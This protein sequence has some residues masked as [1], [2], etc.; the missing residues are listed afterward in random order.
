MEFAV[1][2]LV[3][4]TRKDCGGRRA[5]RE[6]QIW[7]N[8]DT[9]QFRAQIVALCPDKRDFRVLPFYPD[10]RVSTRKRRAAKSKTVRI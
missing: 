8:G 5:P 7:S 4:V 2:D 1:G 9:F 10:G 3:L 6:F